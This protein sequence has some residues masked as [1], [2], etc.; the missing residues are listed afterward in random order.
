MAHWTTTRVPRLLI[1]SFGPLE[2]WIKD[3]QDECNLNLKKLYPGLSAQLGSWYAP[4]WYW[5]KSRTEVHRERGWTLCTNDERVDHKTNC[6]GNTRVLSARNHR[7]DAHVCMWMSAKSSLAAVRLTQNRL[8][9][10]V[11][12]LNGIRKAGINWQ[13]TTPE[14]VELAIRHGR[15]D[16]IVE[17]DLDTKV[18]QDVKRLWLMVDGYCCCDVGGYWYPLHLWVL[19][20]NVC[21]LT[22]QRVV[23][24]DGNTLNNRRSNLA[25]VPHC[26]D[27]GELKLRM[28]MTAAT[29]PYEVMVIVH[30]KEDEQGF[31]RKRRKV[32]REVKRDAPYLEQLYS[33]SRVLDDARGESSCA[34]LKDSCNNV[35]GR[36]DDTYDSAD[37]T[38]AYRN[39]NTSSTTSRL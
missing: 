38:V 16:T 17:L 24:R 20:L 34:F 15:E 8:R 28:S 5:T 36:I 35:L 12:V 7:S 31:R 9:E 10:A 39:H 21:L 18:L 29:G 30:D 4:L 2:Q 6:D 37:P 32:A 22:Q 19:D 33:V 13:R 26:P 1:V 25:I 23:H 11:I 27:E 14:C 3:H